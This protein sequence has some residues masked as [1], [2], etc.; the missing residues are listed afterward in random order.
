MK[1]PNPT[2]LKQELKRQEK[3]LAYFESQCNL[4]ELKDDMIY[5][6]GFCGAAHAQTVKNIAN[7]RAILES[8]EV[9]A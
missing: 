9:Q 4:L 3:A 1:T 8:L 7:T 2:Y 6:A 5:A